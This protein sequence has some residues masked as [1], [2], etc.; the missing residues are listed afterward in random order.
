MTRLTGFPSSLQS[1]RN[2]H[3]S[4]LLYLRHSHEQ[5]SLATRNDD[6]QDIIKL[7]MRSNA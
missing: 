5:P 3:E 6:L 4:A 1:P 7:L 2:T